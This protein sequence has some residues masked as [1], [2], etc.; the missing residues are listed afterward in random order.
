[1][2]NDKH[3]SRHN[4]QRHRPRAELSGRGAAALP[5]ADTATPA[6]VR[7]AQA[8]AKRRN[9][10]ARQ[11]ETL[12]PDGWADRSPCLSP[13]AEDSAACALR[14]KLILDWVA[15][16][17]DAIDEA[18][19]HDL[20]PT[21]TSGCWE[22]AV[23]EVH[24]WAVSAVGAVLTHAESVARTWDLALGQLPRSEAGLAPDS[25]RR[26]LA[27]V[28]CH[29]ACPGISTVIEIEW[30]TANVGLEM[31]GAGIGHVVPAR[32]I[33]EYLDSIGALDLAKCGGGDVGHLKQA[34][35]TRLGLSN[36]RRRH[37]PINTDDLVFDETGG[38]LAVR[39]KRP[40]R[41]SRRPDHGTLAEFLQQRPAGTTAQ[42][43]A[44]HFGISHQ[45]ARRSVGDLNPEFVYR[46]V[47]Q[48]CVAH[49][50]GR[51]AVTW[52]IT[53]DRDEIDK[54]FSEYGQVGREYDVVYQT[55]SN[56]REVIILGHET[57]LRW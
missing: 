24:R 29:D 55:A 15:A 44:D 57:V 56:G 39:P 3:P 49:R 17:L 4:G 53:S 33:G 6:W 48:R 43:I 11:A 23:I 22:G 31:A 9:G 50:H 19:R 52:S 51:G 18:D 25:M 26:V 42:E 34:A 12:L 32:A 54:R 7:A 5:Q 38:L 27:C 47:P 45:S 41:S 36:D 20:E 2:D 16:G 37:K 8:A 35:H 30:P 21:T 40:S 14:S 10:G 28:C 13:I 1:M 46:R